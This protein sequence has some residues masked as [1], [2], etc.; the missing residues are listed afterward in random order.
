MADRPDRRPFPC[1][2]CGGGTHVIETR[3]NPAGLRRRRGCLDRAC[4]MKVTTQEMIAPRGA[5]AK[6]IGDYIFLPRVDWER[7]RQAAMVLLHGV[8]VADSGP[9]DSGPRDAGSG[10][11]VAPAGSVARRSGVAP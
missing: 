6:T 11:D 10:V 8:R 3:L 9:R 7:I 5:S 2:A 1:P 4:G